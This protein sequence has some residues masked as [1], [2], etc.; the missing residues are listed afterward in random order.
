M[1]LINKGLL[2]WL[3]R[4]NRGNAKLSKS[5]NKLILDIEQSDWDTPVEL[6]QYRPD[7]DCVHSKGFTFSIWMF[8]AQ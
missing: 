7:A 5:I 4:N 8:I 3:R 6:K 1:E 2:E